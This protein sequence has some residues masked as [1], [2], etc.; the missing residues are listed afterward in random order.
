VKVWV[1]SVRYDSNQLTAVQS[2]GNR[3]ATG[4]AYLVVN[5]VE[6]RTKVEQ[7]EKRY[8]AIVGGADKVVVD[9]QKRSFGRVE[10]SIG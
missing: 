10:G 2:T 4:V 7:D 1:R 8:F 3:L 5:G 6:S 9:R